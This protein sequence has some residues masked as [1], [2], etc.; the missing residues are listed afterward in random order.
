MPTHDAAGAELTK[1]ARK[2]VKKT[3]DQQ[4][5]KYAKAT[6]TPVLGVAAGGGGGS[7]ADE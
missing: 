3:F 7:A 6:G 5:K 4:A 1:S 2:A